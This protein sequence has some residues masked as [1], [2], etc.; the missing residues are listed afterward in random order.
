MSDSAGHRRQPPSPL[1]F[2][3]ETVLP[4]MSSNQTQKH[5]SGSNTV[6][7]PFIKRHVTRRLKGAKQECDKE[8]Q[9]VTNAITAFFEERLRD[10]DQERDRDREARDRYHGTD[11]EDEMPPPREALMFQPND[12]R[13]AL[14]ID[15]AS[16][17]GGYEAEH[18]GNRSRQRPYISVTFLCWIY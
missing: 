4:S 9:R 12:V 6:S 11:T 8:L 15:D 1:V 16:S 13:P 14:P 18:E 5:G 3:P 17:D 7:M 2:T 10:M